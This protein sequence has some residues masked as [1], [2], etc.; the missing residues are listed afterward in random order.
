MDRRIRINNMEI[1]L[2]EDFNYYQG[3]VEWGKGNSKLED[4]GMRYP[5]IKELSYIHNLFYLNRIGN[6]LEGRYWSGEKDN[7]FDNSYT[8][9]DSYWIYRMNFRG[10]KQ[11][12]FDSGN[13]YVIGIKDI[14]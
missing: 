9:P 12:Q 1:D 10:E 2:F 5:T 8:V 11:T 4:L 14:K 7:R 3:G 13:C 6:I